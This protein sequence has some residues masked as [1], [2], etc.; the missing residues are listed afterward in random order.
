MDNFLFDIV[1]LFFSI[2]HGSILHCKSD[3]LI[4]NHKSSLS[5][6]RGPL[7]ASFVQIFKCYMRWRRVPVSCLLGASLVAF[8]IIWKEM[9]IHMLQVGFSTFILPSFFCW[10]ATFYLLNSALMDLHC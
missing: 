9:D 10:I 4:Y 6:K 3:E 5:T 2:L 8:P 7:F 1:P